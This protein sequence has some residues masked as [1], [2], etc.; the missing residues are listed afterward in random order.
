MTIQP[1]LTLV[2][3]AIWIKAPI[4]KIHGF[5]ANHENYILWFPGVVAISSANNLPHGAVGKLYNETLQLPTGRL[6]EITIRVVESDVPVSL[7]LEGDFPPLHPRTEIRLVSE[8]PEATVLHWR[9]LSRS[10][11]SIGRF[12][13]RA[14]VKNA[15]KRQSEIG[16]R[17]LVSILE[18]RA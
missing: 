18:N 14:L 2:D 9:F 6:R 16:L 5:L 10:Q 3:A 8:S 4:A 12:F 15:V 1:N 7:T 17:K 11:S 13:V